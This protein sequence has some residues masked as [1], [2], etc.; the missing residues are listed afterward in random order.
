MTN[1]QA[2]V[3][4]RHRLADQLTASGDLRSD[5]WRTAVETVPREIFVPQ[6]FRFHPMADKPATWDP[7][8]VG[9][10]L[11]LAEIYSD[12]SLVTQLDGS[13]RPVD[14]EGRVTGT[15]TSSATMPS[16]VVRMW[17][18]LLVDD[19]NQVLEVGTGSGY[20]TALGCA[21]LGDAHITSVDVD[22]DLTSAARSALTAAGYHPRLNTLDAVRAVPAPPQGG[23]DRIIA[24]CSLR[25]VPRSWIAAS[26]AGAVILLTLTGW[27]DA[28]A[29]IRLKVGDDGTATGH[30]IDDPATFMPARAHAAPGLGEFATAAY[31]DQTRPTKLNARIL[32]E[33]VPR[34]LMQLSAPGLQHATSGTA[35]ESTNYFVD[36]TDGSYAVLTADEIRQGGPQRIWDTI[37][38]SLDIWREA[39]SPGVDA[40]EVRIDADGEFVML[41]SHR[42]RLPTA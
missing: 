29:L 19:G 3:G 16:L 15:P 39:G 5:A 32:H 11:V 6:Y 25:S 33:R 27:L 34:L 1:Y 28:A 30:L 18:H 37:E 2:S 42:W 4:L 26:S 35:K 31:N 12:D 23:Y 7:V 40:F 14:T 36:I 22:A 10:E 41:G 13:R 20:S 9:G 8:T 21:R 17:E 24:T 38:Q